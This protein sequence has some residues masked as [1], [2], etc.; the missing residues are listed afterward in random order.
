MLALR[1]AGAALGALAVLAAAP[2]APAQASPP[3]TGTAYGWGLNTYGTVG[4][5]TNTDRTEPTEAAMPSGVTFTTLSTSYWHACS[6]GSDGNGYCWGANSTAGQLGDGTYTNRSR[7]TP[8]Q[9]PSGVTFSAMTAG[10]AH[11]CALGSDDRAYCWGWNTYG[12]LGNGNTTLRST[13][14]RVTMPSGVTFTAISAGYG[15]T[16]AL[17]SDSKTYCW[18]YNGSGQI[19]D[20]SSTNRNVPTEVDLPPGVVFSGVTTGHGHSC[21]LGDDAKAYCWGG[22]SW[23]ELGDSTTTSRN[24]PTEVATPTGVSLTAISAGFYVTCGRDAAGVGYCMGR[25]TNGELGDGTT[26]TRRT[27]VEVSMPAGVTVSAIDPGYEH[28]C[29]LGSDANAYC[30]GSNQKSELGDGTTS[31][32]TVPTQVTVPTG[33]AF[34]AVAPGRDLTTALTGTVPVSD[35]S[36]SSASVGAGTATYIFHFNTSDG[37]T[38]LKDVTVANGQFFTLPTS[39]VACTP[40]GTTLVGWS[41]RGQEA[42]F[43][44]G[45]RVR[46]SGDQTFTAVARDP[47]IAVTYDA[48][49][50]EDTACRSGD[51]DLPVIERSFTITTH[52]DGSLDAVPA[53]TP[54]GATFIGWTDMPTVDGSGQPVT[55]ALNLGLRHAIPQQWNRD[56]N[57]VNEARVYAMWR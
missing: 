31:R 48:N 29:A 50:G 14:Q 7:P 52:R 51:V 18:G 34:S 20:G 13:P 37:G 47:A 23:G 39:E 28:T 22:N 8:V 30:W 25:N 3:D 12:Q 41:I 2:L 49:V 36:S 56:P 35:P 27:P 46:V 10:F 54:D 9:M 40:E 57:P 26:S 33:I 16:C 17:G 42:N 53:C 6:I 4:D 38:C 15:H 44:P 24:A 1:R 43:S 55:R 32:R 21:A 5:G 11:T 19:G 45:G